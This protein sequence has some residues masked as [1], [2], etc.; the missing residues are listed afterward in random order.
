MNP[1]YRYQIDIQVQALRS[2]E[3]ITLRRIAYLPF[4]PRNGDTIRLTSQDDDTM[5]IELQG[6]YYDSKGGVFVFTLVDSQVYDSPREGEPV[7]QQEVV[8]TYAP[9]DFVKLKLHS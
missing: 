9:F 2:G 4:V 1:A 8:A 3:D 6:G 5:D 7:T